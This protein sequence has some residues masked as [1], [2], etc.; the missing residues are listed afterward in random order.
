MRPQLSFVRDAAGAAPRRSLMSSTFPNAL[1][2]PAYLR[3]VRPGAVVA[4]AAALRNPMGHA[5]DSSLGDSFGSPTLRDLI[6]FGVPGAPEGTRFDATR[7]DLDPVD[8]D[9][10]EPDDDPEDEPDDD[11]PLP[12]LGPAT[13]RR[14]RTRRLSAV[15]ADSFDLEA[16]AALVSEG[17]VPIQIGRARLTARIPGLVDALSDSVAEEMPTRIAIGPVIDEALVW[18]LLELSPELVLPG[19]DLYPNN[20][21]RVVETNP[22]F[23]AAFLAGA[24]HEMARELLWREYPADMAATT[25]RRFWDR[26]DLVPDIE[27][28]VDWTPESALADIGS[29]TESVVVLIRGDLVR[30]YPTLRVLLVDPATNIASLPTF[31]GWVPPD[32]RFMAF[33]VDEPDEVTAPGSAWRVV[34]EEQPTE[35]RFGLDTLVEGDQPADP[36]VSWNDLSWDHVGTPIGGHLEIA[37]ALPADTTLEEA[38]WGLNSAHMA[39]ATYQAPYRRTFGVAELIGDS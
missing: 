35:P 25:F 1:V 31:G 22:G 27:P 29:G 36:L 39:Q 9:G 2:S 3:V 21:V 12:T 32:I 15:V 8:D 38:T 11:G 13:R 4:T 6:Q 16:A 20:A 37:G 19:V 5:W 26:P 14:R 30:H 18:S 23:I 24:N 33:D 7:G 10:G 34:L 28:M 17:I